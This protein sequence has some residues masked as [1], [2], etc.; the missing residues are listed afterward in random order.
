MW[1]VIKDNFHIKE[2]NEI[3][4]LVIIPLINYLFS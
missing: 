2:Q 1:A 4:Y 3:I